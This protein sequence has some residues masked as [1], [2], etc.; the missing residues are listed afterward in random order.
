MFFT[1]VGGTALGSVASYWLSLDRENAYWTQDMFPSAISIV[2]PYLGL[3]VDPK[4]GR[5]D[6]EV[7]GPRDVRDLVG[8]KVDLEL[9]LKN[10]VHFVRLIYF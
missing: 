6:R 2:G 3:P 5:L 4:T 8:E 7:L 1:V 9:Q 10:G